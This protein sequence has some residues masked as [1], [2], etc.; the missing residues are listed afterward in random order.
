MRQLWEFAGM[1]AD[2]EPAPEFTDEFHRAL[3]AALLRS[4]SWLTIFMITDLFAR[5]ERFNVPGAI[6]DDNWTQRMH[7]PVSDLDAEPQ[8]GWIRELL[9]AS[10]RAVTKP[11]RKSRSRTSP[12]PD[13]LPEPIQT[14]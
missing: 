10:G 6:G 12:I 9:R 14:A 13:S 1:P 7:V 3:V 5:D 11:K 8:T 4:N 2:Q